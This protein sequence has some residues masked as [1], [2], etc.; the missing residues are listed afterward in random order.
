ME[1]LDKILES[2]KVYFN[3]CEELNTLLLSPEITIDSKL[4]QK[5]AKEAQEIEAY[6]VLYTKIKD[7]VLERETFSAY[8]DFIKEIDLK[9]DNL[10]LEYRELINNS[11]SDS[12]EGCII[13]I[14]GS[15]KDFIDKLFKMYSVFCK[16]QSYKYSIN[17]NKMTIYGKNAY[18]KLKGECG[19]CKIED[20]KKEIK[21]LVYPL[22][23]AQENIINDKDIKVDYF[24]S[25]GAG[26]QNINKVETA[27]RL[28]HIPTGIVV[29]CQDERSQKQNKEKAYELLEKKLKERSK[30]EEKLNFEKNRKVILSKIKPIRVYNI[31]NNTIKNI[32]SEKLYELNKALNCAN[33]IGES[34]V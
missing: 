17:D 8:P 1:N 20:L 2:L 28:T 23:K 31:S 5:Y 11:K 25:S 27:I 16:N 18:S 14:V 19:I 15:E 34:I 4:N 6:G 33:I 32:N 29:T 12:Y 22:E 21:V 26:G 10:I 13:E 7:C 30:Q 24:H 3:R 9:L